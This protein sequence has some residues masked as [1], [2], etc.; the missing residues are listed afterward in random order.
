MKVLFLG[1]IFGN[2]GRTCISRELPKL[3]HKHRAD[4]V[5]ANGENAAGGIGINP[6]IADFLLDAGIDVITSGNHIYKKKEIYDYINSQPRLI[7]PANFPPDTPGNGYYIFSNPKYLAK[8]VAVVNVCGRVFVENL[9]CPFRK[10]DELLP[11]IYS[12]TNIV[13]V[14]FHAE[15]TSEKMAMGWYLDGR[16]SAVIG[17]HTHVQTA[18]ERIL[19][20]GTAFISDA[21]MVGPRDSV[22]G[23]KKELII[24]RF[25][26]MMPQKF[27]V[28]SDD[29]WIN[30]VV[31]DIDEST[32]KS[33]SINRI[34]YSA[35]S[36]GI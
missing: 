21:G 31:V 15:V 22:I 16:V 14:D 8:K 20:R 24:D 23:V 12:Q 17:T 26:K 34:N 35:E 18:D 11:A 13:I 29:N 4:I 6:A 3:V 27:V 25:I 5:I 30:G 36:S 1:D 9:D 19:P 28:A 7:K 10:M 32:G 33:K 2:P